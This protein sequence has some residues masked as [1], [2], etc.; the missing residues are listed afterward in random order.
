[1]KQRGRKSAASL[2]AVKKI[3]QRPKAPG[4]LTPDQKKI[5]KKTV[6][7]MAV[8]WFRPETHDIL[9]QY[10]VHVC[11]SNR[12]RILIDGLID[13]KLSIKLFGFYDKLLKMQ[14]REGRALSSLATRM[15]LTQQSTYRPEKNKESPAKKSWQNA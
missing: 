12:I 6:D 13:D 10:C 3:P 4:D 11:E 14:E 5:W 1:M 15:R 2:A 8:D 9:R 7:A